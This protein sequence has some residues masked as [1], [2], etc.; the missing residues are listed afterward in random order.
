MAV[1]VKI[2][3]LSKNKIKQKFPCQVDLIKYQ[4]DP[5][6]LNL[7][8]IKFYSSQTKKTNQC[9]STFAFVASKPAR[10]LTENVSKSDVKRAEVL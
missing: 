10:V 2:I 1:V 7:I 5:I 9:N 8:Y 6:L 3:M 4:P